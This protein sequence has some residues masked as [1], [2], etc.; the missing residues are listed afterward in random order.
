M[1][2]PCTDGAL[3]RGDRL[4][5][6]ASRVDRWLLVEHP[7]PWGPPALP[8][9]R[10]PADEASHLVDLAR[11]AGARLLLLRRPR[12]STVGGRWI[13]QVDSRP[14][15][16][17]VLASIRP[18]LRDLDL[19]DDAWSEVTAP[20]LLVCTHGRHDRCCA[21]RG[22]P[23]AEALLAAR[24]DD[25]WECSHVGGD[26]F[27]A[28]LL[29]LPAGLY[30]GQLSAPEALDVVSALAGGR[31]P[32]DRLRGRSTAS[33]V[34]QAAE[35]YARTVLGRDRLDDLLP[36]RPERATELAEGR[37]RV[38]LRGGSGQP[39]VEVVVR[40]VRRPPALLTCAATQARPRGSQ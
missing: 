7:G 15:S 5:G 28:N 13:Y 31:L 25:T 39:D 8:T 40:A 16:E 36:G 19:A 11:D 12:R 1:T 10:L 37:W 35:H 18:E 23:V 32:L 9:S 4:A 22:R 38:V 27:A 26:R 24:P 20:L 30:F 34:A 6:T 21:V 14:G 17:S 33:T 2:V 29:V 3:A